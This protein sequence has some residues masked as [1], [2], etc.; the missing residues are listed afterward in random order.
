MCCVVL[1]MTA[2]GLWG[3]HLQPN[4][5]NRERRQR[6]PAAFSAINLNWSTAKLRGL[7]D[8]EALSSSCTACHVWG[9]YRGN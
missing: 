7:E 9:G 8:P 3:R 4:V 2:V 5:L 1:L 6:C